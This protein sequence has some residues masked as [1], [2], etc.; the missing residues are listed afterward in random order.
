MLS[1]KTSKYNTWVPFLINLDLFP[2]VI[3]ELIGV[4]LV[5]ESDAILGM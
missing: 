4:Q 2:Y 1:V 3:E 5:P